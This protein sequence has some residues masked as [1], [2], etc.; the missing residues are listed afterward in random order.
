[1]IFSLHLA[2]IS[3]MLGAMNLKYLLIITLVNIFTFLKICKT[4]NQGDF[5]LLYQ[6]PLGNESNYPSPIVWERGSILLKKYIL[7]KDIYRLSYYNTSIHY[8]NTKQTNKN[9]N[10]IN[11]NNKP[12][13]NNKLFL[14]ESNNNIGL[15]PDSKNIWKF[16][17]GYKGLSKY[18]HN[19]A[20]DFIKKGEL[21]DLDIINDILSYSNIKVTD[22]ELKILLNLRKYNINTKDNKKMMDDINNLLGLSK[23]KNQIPGIYIFTH[24]KTGRKYVGSSSQ[25]S[26]RLY[27]Y[28]KKKDKSEGLIRPLLYKEGIS[29]FLLEVIPIYHKWY[30]RVELV[31]EQYYLLNPSFNLNIIK[32]ANNPSGSN[33][34]PLYMYNR[35]KT[36][37]YYYSYQQNNFI[38]YLKIHFETFKKHLNNNTYYLG[39]YSFSRTLVETAMI[40]NITL[41]DLGLKLE[42]DRIKF[43]KNK[44]IKSESWTIL[45][46]PIN[47]PKETLLFNGYRS[48]IKFLRNEKDIKTTRE[49][50]I[51]YIKNG[52]PFYGYICKLI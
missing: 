25:L 36:I 50:L 38:K 42:K 43:N 15:Q 27:N 10:I 2:G 34:K 37:L 1:M 8:N 28:I 48:C 31:L 40:S 30:F 51:K 11:N 41:T 46:T 16:I 26:I 21:P 12:K 14:K 39:K 3:S 9:N 18:A 17:K 23:D 5:V 32:V 7:Y 47:K 20:R 13:N 6:V 35:D 45:L 4:I 29:E 19:K 49:T 22:K 52:L 33:S 44:P 24:I